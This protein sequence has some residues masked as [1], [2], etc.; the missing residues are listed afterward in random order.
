MDELTGALSRN[1]FGTVLKDEVTRAR[2]YGLD[3][4]LVHFDVE[5]MERI[6]TRHGHDAGDCALRM[7]AEIRQ[8]Q[9]EEDR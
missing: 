9:P 7:I 1:R 2:R 4:S 6:N 3:V 5:H 8:T